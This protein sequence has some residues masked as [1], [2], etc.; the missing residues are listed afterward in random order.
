MASNWEMQTERQVA[1]NYQ[2]KWTNFGRSPVG[3]YHPRPSSPFVIIF[4]PKANTLLP[5][6]GDGGML[7]R[8]RYCSK[9]VQQP[10]PKAVYHTNTIARGEVRTSDL[11]HRTH[12][13]YH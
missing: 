6:H 10:M 7:S 11:S 4:S 13:C 8:P 3:C 2:T 12:A 5:S 9:G 1:A